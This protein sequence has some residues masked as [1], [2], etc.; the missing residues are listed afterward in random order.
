MRLFDKDNYKPGYGLVIGMI[1]GTIFYIPVAIAT[2]S[3]WLIGV[4]PAIGVAI[5]YA[6]DEYYKKK[7]GL[8]GEPQ[9]AEQ[10]RTKMFIIVATFTLLLIMMLSVL[11]LRKY[12]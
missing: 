9:T 1:L 6:I 5:G 12:S 3:L 8:S 11:Y 10:V 4:G 2:N 7:F